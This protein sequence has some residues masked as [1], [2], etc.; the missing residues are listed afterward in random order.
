MWI[1]LSLFLTE[2]LKL[3]NSERNSL[4]KKFL[5]SLERL[6][7]LE[8]LELVK[9]KES[10][11]FPLNLKMSLLEMFTREI[12]LKSRRIISSRLKIKL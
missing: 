7:L 8:R 4:K 5:E 6:C 11:S 1:T 9:Q 2:T 10:E 12:K 3:L